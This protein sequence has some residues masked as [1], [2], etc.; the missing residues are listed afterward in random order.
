MA[1]TV[2]LTYRWISVALVVLFLSFFFFPIYVAA[3]NGSANVIPVVIN[4]RE[5]PFTAIPGSSEGE[6]LVSLRDVAGETGLTV[7]W[8]EETK[9]VRLKDS[10][11]VA[12]LQVGCEVALVGTTQYNL[13]EALRLSQGRLLV[14]VSFFEDVFGYKA[15][16]EEG[17]LVIT[18]PTEKITGIDFA[19]KDGRPNVT[20]KTSGIPRFESYLLTEPDRIVVDFYDTRLDL[21]GDV[22]TCTD[23]PPESRIKGIRW[24]Q[25]KSNVAR[26]VIDLAQ[27]IG[28]EILPSLDGKGL[29]VALFRQVE[30]VS[31]QRVFGKAQLTVEGVG[32][33]DYSVTY[34]KNPDRLV[35]DLEKATLVTEG[36]EIEIDDP[37]VKRIRMHQF[38]PN[39]VRVVLD[40]KYPAGYVVAPADDENTLVLELV[41]KITGV[42]VSAYQGR[43]S[44][45][46]KGFG[47]DEYRVEYFPDLA[48]ILVDIPSAMLSTDQ[49]R[50]SFTR[51]PV[52]DIK[53]LQVAPT[54]VQVQIGLRGYLGHETRR[55]ADGLQVLVNNSPLA[56][57][58]IVLDPGHGGQDPGAI[59]RS[60]L[61]E[62]DVVLDI[63]LK[64]EKLLES[65]GAE[66]IMVRDA[67]YY[68]PL[69]ERA[70]LAN[71]A[72]ADVFI[73]IHVN[74]SINRAANGAETY[75][76][77]ADAE[78]QELAALI[79]REMLA[80][81][82]LNNRA[83]R[84]NRDF[85]VLKETKLTSVL[86]EVAFISNRAEEKK[87]KDPEFRQK[88]AEAIARG[89][90]SY[91]GGPSWQ[92]RDLIVESPQEAKEPEAAPEEEAAPEAKEEAEKA[93][94]GVKVFTWE[95][96]KVTPTK[97]GEGIVDKV[98]VI[99]IQ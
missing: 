39:I 61:M 88:A 46:I 94:S 93:P 47:I 62:K 74:S 97:P 31:F 25:F 37:L 3:E 28:Y 87:L 35:V 59:G 53:L 84:P 79:Q 64:L 30:G 75:Y 29:T 96:L 71:T 89:L 82:D 10:S 2:A 99:E 95:S 41:K 50:L 67:D 98:K 8:L 22:A 26:I 80:A 73:S 57:R 77:Y 48:Q 54:T 38:L 66:V 5:L 56:G 55:V 1:K 14:P 32:Q 11:T 63:A 13:S 6:W 92:F 68:V 43:E 91:F 58:R 19:M 78:G 45:L 15:V 23:L 34:L 21:N 17:K 76:Y 60:G 18:T 69:M 86:T 70:A 9:T 33:E 42:A 4:G 40:L 85:V 81:L 36:E 12:Y 51:G 65:Q 20:I 90:A 83:P 16:V 24:D 44:L 52:T 49:P 27:G 72:N 7:G